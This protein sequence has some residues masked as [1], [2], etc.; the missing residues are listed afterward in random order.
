MSDYMK[1]YNQEEALV[2]DDIIDASD[3]VIDAAIPYARP[4]MFIY[5]AGQS[6]VK[7]KGLDGKWV[8][9]QITGKDGTPGASAYELAKASDPEVGD[10]DGWL[11]S[12]KG[13]SGVN[14]KSITGITLEV[15]KAGAIT[16]GTATMDDQS[17]IPI[18]VTTAD[19]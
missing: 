3:E 10:L 18:T 9:V 4:G 12:L 2:T 5:N 8:T 14:G 6:K 13:T 15:T 19:A 17:T 16:G 7:Q 1:I 11:E